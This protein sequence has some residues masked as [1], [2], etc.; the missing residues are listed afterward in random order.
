MHKL[1]CIIGRTGSGKS[2]LVK[3]TANELGLKI[4]KSYTTRPMR[5]SESIEN[6][7][8]IFISPDEVGK[9][10]DDMVAYTERVDYCNFATK[11]QI[12]SSDL[13]IINPSGY[14]ELLKSAEKMDVELIPILI[15]APLISIISRVQESRN[16]ETWMCNC[17]NENDEF[18][19]FEHSNDAKYIIENNKDIYYAYEILEL[20]INQELGKTIDIPDMLNE[21][22][23]SILD[24]LRMVD[25]MDE[26]SVKETAYYITE[27]LKNVMRESTYESAM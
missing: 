22:Q 14:K 21:F 6:S 27:T 20:I 12:M 26:N 2:T 7:D 5:E 13:Y 18:T 17:L 24:H 19:I 9:Y 8:H 1:F 25:P 4:L 23:D 3:K 15:T 16:L 11:Q 10:R